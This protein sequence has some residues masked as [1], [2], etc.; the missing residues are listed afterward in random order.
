[1]DKLNKRNVYIILLCNIVTCVL[2]YILLQVFHIQLHDTYITLMFEVISLIYIFIFAKVND[3]SLLDFGLR[4][5]N[6]KKTIGEGLFISWI[7]IIIGIIAKLIIIKVKPDFFPVGMPFFRWKSR[8]L[9]GYFYI[10]TS[11]VQE[12]IIQGVIHNVLNHLYKEK[13]GIAFIICSIIFS[14]SHFAKGFIM[15]I[16][17]SLLVIVLGLIYN[18]HD[19]IWATFI[20]HYAVGFSYVHLFVAA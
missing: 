11:F 20:I 4:I 10:V 2:A 13:S 16:G 6:P 15:M 1:M 12:F 17:A 18:R 5:K 8:S 9:L 3:I 14:V 7:L 19:S